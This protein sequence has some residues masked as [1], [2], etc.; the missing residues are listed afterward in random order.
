MWRRL[1]GK[2][3]ASIVLVLCVVAAA[4]AAAI[5]WEPLRRVVGLPPLAASLSPQQQGL[6]L[7]K[8]Y[9]Y[10]G[11]RLVAT[12]EPTPVP[13]GPPP[14]NLVAT[15]GTVAPPAATVNVSWSA[16]ESG[17]PLSY[18]VERKGA[19]GQF[20]AVGLPVS[21]PTTTFNDTSATEGSAYLYRVKAV[22]AGGVS[23]VYSN[24]DLATAVAFTNDPLQVGVT[25][26]YARHLTE[27][28]RAVDA[29]RTLAG[30]GLSSWQSN[31]APAQGGL[32]LAAHYLELRTNL[33]PALAAL[34][35]AQMPAD[36]TLA[37]GMPVRV[38]HI[39]DVREAV[40]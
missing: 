28:R 13:A 27:L 10:A 4:S 23:S 16:P 36:S 30:V 34:G 25:A 3:A 8:E 20:Q 38:A 6:P 14:T 15:T 18:V 22:Y 26:I 32:V 7:S 5:R 31:P 12:E 39:Q 1:A 2:R 37:I 33:N 9:V 19:G 21:A 11:G 35:I 24:T 40:R 29:V 17:S